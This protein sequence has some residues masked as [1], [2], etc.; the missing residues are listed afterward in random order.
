MTK[1]ER[2]IK[3]VSESPGLLHQANLRALRLY[4]KTTPENQVLTEIKQISN[5]AYLRTLWEAGLTATQ[6]LAVINKLEELT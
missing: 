4:L 2:L 3:T 5:V 6:Q 1:L